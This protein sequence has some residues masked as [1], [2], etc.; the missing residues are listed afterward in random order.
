MG[1]CFQCEQLGQLETRGGGR[2]V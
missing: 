1:H 2:N